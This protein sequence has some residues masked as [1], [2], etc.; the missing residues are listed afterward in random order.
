M[1]RM[2]TQPV[3]GGITHQNFNLKMQMTVVNDVATDLE[4]LCGWYDDPDR[5]YGGPPPKE[6]LAIFSKRLSNAYL[7]MAVLSGLDPCE[8]LDS[9]KARLAATR[10]KRASSDS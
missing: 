1:K 5:Q 10:E 6:L 7:K 4:I 8:K 2:Q 9:T 3:D